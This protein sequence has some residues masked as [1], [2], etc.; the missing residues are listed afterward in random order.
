L[1]GS[2]TL[3]QT[4]VKGKASFPGFLSSRVGVLKKP[5]NILNI[6][7]VQHK[8]DTGKMAGGLK[9]THSFQ[10]EYSKITNFNHMICNQAFKYMLQFEVQIFLKCNLGNFKYV[11]GFDVH[12]LLMQILQLNKF[13][14]S[15]HHYLT[16]INIV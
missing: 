3:S 12:L 2:R 6:Q 13:I 4:I 5:E 9:P 10:C 11:T 16:D 7:I 8:G 14:C 15:K 1:P